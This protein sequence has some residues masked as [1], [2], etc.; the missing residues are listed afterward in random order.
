[1]LSRE[2]F[3]AHLAARNLTPNGIMCGYTALARTVAAPVIVRTVP[4][5]RDRSAVKRDIDVLQAIGLVDVITT[6]ND[7]DKHHSSG[8][9]T[10]IRWQ[11]PVAA[12]L[13]RFIAQRFIET[14]RETGSVLT[15]KHCN[16]FPFSFVWM[17]RPDLLCFS[18]R[19]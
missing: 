18:T 17:F 19:S 6:K 11:H 4:V 13:S 9:H 7:E 2:K 15:F 12:Y 14:E 3:A 10:S 16:L 5:H 8:T 1:M